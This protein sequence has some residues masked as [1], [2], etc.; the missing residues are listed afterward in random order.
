M[1][2]KKIVHDKDGFWFPVKTGIYCDEV[3]HKIKAR[4]A[5]RAEQAIL[6]EQEMNRSAISGTDNSA[7][8]HGY[9]I[10]H[11]ED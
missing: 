6:V 3:T 5:Q 7:F 10:C 11:P 9:V 4:S 8:R 2:I 1:P